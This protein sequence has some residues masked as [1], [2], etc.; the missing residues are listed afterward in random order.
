MG[1]HDHKQAKAGVSLQLAKTPKTEQF[2]NLNELHPAWRIAKLE[3]CDPFG[4]HELDSGKLTEIRQRLTELEKLTWNEIL[5]KNRYWNHAVERY[6]LSPEAQARLRELH[7]EDQEE[8]VSLRLSNFE[9]VWGIR[10][11]G[12]MTLLWW[13]PTHAVCPNLR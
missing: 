6:R 13:D 3:M 2:P 11:E 9:R 8:L 1:K 5:V 12:A 10:I 7:L 4:W